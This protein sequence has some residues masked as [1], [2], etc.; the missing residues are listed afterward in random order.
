M[1]FFW[2]VVRM[3]IIK[4]KFLASCSTEEKK[5]KKKT[6]WGIIIELFFSH[7]LSLCVARPNVSYRWIR[8]IKI[9]CFN[10]MNQLNYIQITLWNVVILPLFSL[11]CSDFLAFNRMIRKVNQTLLDC[12]L[13]LII[14]FFASLDNTIRLHFHSKR[15]SRFNQKFIFFSLRKMYVK[16]WRQNESSC[17]YKFRSHKN[18]WEIIYKVSLA[19]DSRTCFPWILAKKKNKTNIDSFMKDHLSTSSWMK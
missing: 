1:I 9:E 3:N 14:F 2:M 7:E 13:I 8:N 6:Q 4:F 16:P 12:S 5:K 19:Y 11:S 17:W 18:N 15:S 10:L